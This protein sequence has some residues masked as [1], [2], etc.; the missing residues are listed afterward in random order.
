ML[1]ILIKR[2]YYYKEDVDLDT[3]FYFKVNTNIMRKDIV[4]K[5]LKPSSKESAMRELNLFYAID[6][7]GSMRGN[8]IQ[9]VNEVMPEVMA[10]VDRISEENKD[11]AVIKASVL[12]FNE[13]AEWMFPNPIYASD[14]Q[15]NWPTLC[16]SGKTYFGVMCD[17][18]EKALHWDKSVN[19]MAQLNNLVGHNAPAII[20]ISDGK[21][22]DD[23]WEIHLERLYDNSWFKEASR[24]A[25][26]IGN[27]CDKNVLKTFVGE[28]DSKIYTVHNIKDLKSAIKIVS[29]V[30]SIMGSKN[31]ITLRKDLNKQLPLTIVDP[32]GLE[33]D[34]FD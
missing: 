29:S 32:N 17:T 22:L 28:D 19:S 11:N 18:L 20:L 31:G 2:H 6:I 23:D 8:K 30:A 9:A 21:P 10:L 5:F 27:D 3:R 34:D 26:A 15:E 12:M 14:M 24:I 7:S 4:R 13:K 16:A 25:I 33:I 1:T